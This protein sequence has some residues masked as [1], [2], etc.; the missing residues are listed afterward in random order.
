MRSSPQTSWDRPPETIRAKSPESIMIVSSSP[1]CPGPDGS[2]RTER[3]HSTRSL[4]P[5]C[6]LAQV[7]RNQLDARN[8]ERIEPG[9]GDQ[10]RRNEGAKGATVPLP[11]Q[12]TSGLRVDDFHDIV[13]IVVPP[14]ILVGSR[15][16]VAIQV[17]PV[18]RLIPAFSRYP[19]D[20]PEASV[21]IEGHIME[22]PQCR[23]SRRP[24][25]IMARPC[26]S[27]AWMTSLSRTEPPGWMMA[28]TP[29]SAAASTPSRKGKKGSEASVA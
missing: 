2:S 27:A 14:I 6:P 26:S 10:A 8:T 7:D 15:M 22:V 11:Q 20:E 12:E 25:K 28:R 21:R 4:F 19:K 5:I 23:K 13:S 3:Q 16:T 17:V 29:A 1:S 18:Q 24:V 9:P